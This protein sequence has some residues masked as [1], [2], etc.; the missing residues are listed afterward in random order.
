M[1]I[2]VLA[3]FAGCLGAAPVYMFNNFVVPQ[4]NALSQTYQGFD[5]YATEVANAR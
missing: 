3:L 2:L 4:L 5:A 1:K